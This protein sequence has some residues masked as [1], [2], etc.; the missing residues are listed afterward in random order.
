M[1]SQC[2][3]CVKQAA[4]QCADNHSHPN[5]HRHG[6]VRASVARQRRARAGTDCH[7]CVAQTA[8]TTVGVSAATHG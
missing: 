3:D 1:V 7:T 6:P 5:G 2:P 8:T 4:G